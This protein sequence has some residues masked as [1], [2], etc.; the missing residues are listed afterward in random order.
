[1]WG[2]PYRPTQLTALDR[3]R[4]RFLRTFLKEVKK[5]GY[6]VKGQAPHR[7]S[8]EAGKNAMANASELST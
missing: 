6:K 2:S 7:L 3:R 8:L 1:M 5:L 4:Q